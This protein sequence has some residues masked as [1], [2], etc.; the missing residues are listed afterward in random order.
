MNSSGTTRSDRGAG[1][2]PWLTK[3]KV[4]CIALCLLAA[5]LVYFQPTLERWLGMDSEPAAGAF[6]LEEIGP[7][8]FRS[9]VNRYLCQLQKLPALIRG[10]FGD[11]NLRYITSA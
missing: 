9:L 8:Q 5:G 6:V 1:Q 11:H 10:F 4:S 7:D 2:R 3:K